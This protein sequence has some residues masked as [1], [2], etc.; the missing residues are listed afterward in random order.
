MLYTILDEEEEA[1][2]AKEVQNRAKEALVS[3]RTLM[4]AKKKLGVTSQ[5]TVTESEDGTDQITQWVWKLPKDQAILEP[6]KER[7]LC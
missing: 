4:R 6:Y 5:R 2:P 3:Q 1:V 7:L